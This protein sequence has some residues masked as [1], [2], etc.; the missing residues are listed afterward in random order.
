MVR[1]I[2]IPDHS[3]GWRPWPAERALKGLGHRRTTKSESPLDFQISRQTNG[4]RR[5][6]IVLD[7]WIGDAL[8]TAPG[9]G[10]TEVDQILPV[11]LVDSL[12]IMDEF[13][14]RLTISGWR[15]LWANWKYSATEPSF[16]VRFVVSKIHAY[17][18]RI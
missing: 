4:Y 15:S 2:S 16:L 10:L 14:D 3:T 5:G 8:P 12:E 13:G 6:P 9:N 18:N 7:R 1:R 11:E 17:M